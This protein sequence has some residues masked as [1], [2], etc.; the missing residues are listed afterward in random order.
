MNW[1]GKE[2]NTETESEEVICQL[3]ATVLSLQ[4]KNERLNEMNEGMVSGLDKKILR[5]QTQVSVLETTVDM[6]QISKKSLVCSKI[7]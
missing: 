1:Q 6:P 3:K 2:T 5:L 7:P 4:T